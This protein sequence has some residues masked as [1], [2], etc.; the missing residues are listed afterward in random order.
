M[1]EAMFKKMLEDRNISGIEVSS[2]GITAFPG[3]PASEGAVAVMAEKG[4]DL[5]GHTARHLTP[6]ILEKA[7]LILTMT[8]SHEAYIANKIPEIAERVHTLAVYA[9]DDSSALD[10]RD[11]F[12]SNIEE[13]KECAAQIYDCLE[14]IFDRRKIK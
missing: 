3:D 2:A 4:I 14:R 6:D 1:A 7:G 11:P 12:G 10:I 13:Y 8:R 5:T 9:Y